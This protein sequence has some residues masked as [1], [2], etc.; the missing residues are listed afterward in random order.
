LAS[1]LSGTLIPETSGTP[2]VFVDVFINALRSVL[3]TYFRLEVAV[4]HHRRR[5]AGYLLEVG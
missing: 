5:R 1:L 2:E 4:S 3:L